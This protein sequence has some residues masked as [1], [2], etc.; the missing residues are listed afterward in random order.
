[1]RVPVQVAVGCLV[2]DKRV[3]IG[4][5]LAR[6][7][8]SGEWEFPGGKLEANETPEIALVREFIEETGLE[9]DCWRPLINYSWMHQ[10]PKGPI[11]VHLHVFITDTSSG[12]IT[13]P[14]GHTFEWV[15][16]D[17][18]DQYQML[19]ANK[20]IV[21]ALQLPNH[22]VMAPEFVN[23]P[24]PV[25]SGLDT[26]LAH[27]KKLI[28]FSAQQGQGSKDEFVSLANELI[29]HCHV[30][31][32]KLI[33]KTSIDWFNAIPLADGLQIVATEL[34]EHAVRPISREKLLG[35]VLQ[36]PLD[37][38]KA[39]QVDADF[40]LASPAHLAESNRVLD[41]TG[42]V[43]LRKLI[44]SSPI[45]VF[46]LEDEYF[47]DDEY[48]IGCGAQGVARAYEFWPEVV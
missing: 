25:L 11:E 34:H 2:K 12:E 32:A 16:I 10:L 5:R 36:N 13:A 48:A 7:S 30:R 22:Y 38:D 46:A 35:V 18:L 40:I 21:R 37:L 26:A 9:T 47:V 41:P 1:M 24:Q 8:F 3:L 27:G 45:P 39:L 42:W 19:I 29:G 4:Q 33:V 20:G 44:A 15:A 6:Q 43:E 17:S 31:G 14:E 28:V 23:D